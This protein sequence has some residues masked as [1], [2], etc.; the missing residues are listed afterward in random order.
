MLL[1]FHAPL[2]LIPGAVAR[3][4]T[5]PDS[6]MYCGLDMP[7]YSGGLFGHEKPDK[8]LGIPFGQR[9][10]MKLSCN[11]L[12]LG[13]ARQQVLEDLGRAWRRDVLCSRLNNVLK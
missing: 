4:Q 11:T 12:R 6:C 3:F 10:I 7:Q 5:C 9:K 8:K 13:G 2:R 1:V